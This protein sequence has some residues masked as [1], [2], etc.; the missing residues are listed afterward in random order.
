MNR[1]DG[2][3]AFILEHIDLEHDAHGAVKRGPA[4][5]KMSELGLRQLN[6]YFGTCLADCVDDIRRGE[7]GRARAGIVVDE[8][9]R[10][11]R[12]VGLD[13]LLELRRVQHAEIGRRHREHVASLEPRR[14][15]LNEL[16]K[17][18]SKQTT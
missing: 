7:R 5:P 15:T 1:T 9:L 16:R 3:N 2:L 11:Y 13:G 10:V 14:L 18:R 17:I 12:E 4:G 8:T 6:Q